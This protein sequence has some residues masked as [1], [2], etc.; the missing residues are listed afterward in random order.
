[1]RVVG[2]TG[3]IGS[4]K[5]TVAALLRARGLPVVDADEVA[6]DCTGRPDVLAAVRDRFGAGVLA[7]DGGL[8]RAALAAVVFADPV[9]R[10]DL[11]ALTHPCIRAGV[12]ARIAALRA[13]DPAPQVVVVEH[14]LLLETD[15][16]DR[17]DTVVV[18]DAPLEVRVARTVAG[19]GLP[20]ADV[21]AR[22]AAQVGDAVRRAAADHV[23]ANTGDRTALA[24]AV[25]AML[26]ALDVRAGRGD[27]GS[28]EG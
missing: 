11:E 16:V 22:A 28:E 27:A 1:M 26:V 21:R 23:V 3:G 4:G 8:D 9:A 25:D 10:R 6:R 13:L 5:S 24:A 19:R 20:E 18:V 14:P 2:L 7:A 15:A 17:V 12:A